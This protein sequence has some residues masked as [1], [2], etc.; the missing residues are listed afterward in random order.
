MCYG[1]YFLSR[2]RALGTSPPLLRERLRS[3]SCLRCVELFY[4]WYIL[5]VV[6]WAF[7]LWYIELFLWFMG[8]SSNEQYLCPWKGKRYCYTE[9]GYF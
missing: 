7:L 9:L 5:F 1:H 3:T 8:L 6:Y 2:I 4:L